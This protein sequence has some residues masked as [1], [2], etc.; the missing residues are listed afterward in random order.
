MTA[1]RPFCAALFLL[2]FSLPGCP[3]PAAESTRVSPSFDGL[4][5]AGAGLG[6]SSF[7]GDAL[8]N[9]RLGETSFHD[10]LLL[11]PARSFTI[12]G[13][14]IV[15]TYTEREQRQTELRTVT[16]RFTAPP[17]SS[18]EEG[19]LSSITLHLTART[20]DLEKVLDRLGGDFEEVKLPQATNRYQELAASTYL[21]RV[22]PFAVDADATGVHI[23]ATLPKPEP[24]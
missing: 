4:N 2:G 20:E 1:P 13:A 8:G 3:P 19:I 10:F 14:E 12:D 22:A 5:K 23:F 17:G 15:F 7:R 24:F 11:V 9:L 16:L 21:S 18:R 6:L